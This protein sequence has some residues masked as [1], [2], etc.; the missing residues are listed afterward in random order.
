MSISRKTKEDMANTVV[1]SRSDIYF[2]PFYSKFKCYC[3]QCGETYTISKQ[4]LKEIKNS[5]MCPRCWRSATKISDSR[6]Q[7]FGNYVLVPSDNK[8]SALGYRVRFKWDLNKM[9]SASTKLVAKFSG[10]NFGEE[11]RSYPK[12]TEVRDIHLIPFY[13]GIGE[14]QSQTGKWKKRTKS[15]RYFENMYEI[16]YPEHCQY[17]HTPKKTKKEY[18]EESIGMYHL[19]SSQVRIA[20]SHIMNPIQ[21]Q[22]M[23]MFDINDYE[24]AKK[25]NNLEESYRSRFDDNVVAR[26]VE[27]RLNKFD[28]EYIK[29]NRLSTID[30]ID[31]LFDC[32][33]IGMKNKHPKDFRSANTEVT[34]II[35]E[36]IKREEEYRIKNSKKIIKKL[37]A[38]LPSKSVSGIVI[39]PVRSVEELR[40]S[41]KYMQNCIM[42]YMN[43]YIT[44]KCFLYIVRDDSGKI[45]ANVE[46]D[47][48]QII[49][50]RGRYNS[51]VPKKISNI[52]KKMV[53]DNRKTLESITV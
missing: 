40:E 32:D 43:K 38:E 44:G 47:K 53:S 34:R 33:R 7:N 1:R 50:I 21:L 3:T 18:L 42:S 31:Y 10:I 30:Y 11:L 29:R 45:L 49:Q 35:N 41:A 13:G 26:C 9:V 22:R 37:S 23:V 51:S 6:K 2:K 52:I 4:E 20:M 27:M 46:L 39:S 5:H 12:F 16:G 8:L 28:A 36:Q 17:G 24:I 19:K 48:S 15:T 14:D 25:Y